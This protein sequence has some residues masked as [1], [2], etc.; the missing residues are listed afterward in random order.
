DVLRTVDVIAAEDTRVS[1]KLLRHYAIA[2]TPTAL[3]A[4]NERHRAAAIVDALA[5]GKSVALITDAGT[6]GIS[7]P[8]ARLVQAVRAA[9]HP[10]V[11]IP[12]ACA[13]VAAVSAAGLNAE[14]F[15]FLGFLPA[16]DKACRALLDSFARLPCALVLYEA[17]HRIQQTV[18]TLCESLGAD[19]TLVVARELTKTFETIATLEL[20]SAMEWF[21]ADS[22]RTRGEFVLIVDAADTRSAPTRLTP[23][24]EGWIKALAPELPPARV[25][26]IV[27]ERTGVPREACYAKALALKNGRSEPS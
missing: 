26:R 23:E 5:S 21:V 7:D 13:L 27:A 14:R 15:A 25:A 3:H 22:N 19:R 20:G 11:P 12:G 24:A 8:G 9:G 2:R 10:V 6:P 4:H 1:A 18:A 17:P 16:Q